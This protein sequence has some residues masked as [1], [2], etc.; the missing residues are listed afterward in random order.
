MPRFPDPPMFKDRPILFL[1]FEMTGLDV[2]Q[3]EIVEIAALVVTQ[4]DLAIIN[5]YY[6]KVQPQHIQTADPD[7]LEVI[8]Y[9]AS[10]WQDAIPLRQALLELSQLAPECILAGFAIQNEWNFLLAALGREGLPHFF[11]H[12][13][14][15]IWTLAFTKFYRDPQVTN[16]GLTNL[17]RLFNIPLERHKPDSDIRATYEIFKHL[18]G[19]QNPAG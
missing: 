14:L 10:S 7:S 5:N 9:T 8:G 18:V 6:T 12:N 15:E 2:N 13:L 4:P 19:H 1:D 17:S 11:N 3:H 16:I